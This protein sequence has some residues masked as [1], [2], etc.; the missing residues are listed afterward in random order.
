MS[1]D[2]IVLSRLFAFHP[3][4]QGSIEAASPSLSDDLP[5]EV[6]QSPVYSV[7]R[8]HQEV[9]ILQRIALSTF[10]INSGVHDPY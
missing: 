3:E 5:D 8:K 9:W 7:Q 2:I 6:I 1:P 10:T 4:A